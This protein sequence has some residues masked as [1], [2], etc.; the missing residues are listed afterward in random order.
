MP[1]LMYH[2]IADDGPGSLV[3]WRVPE[4]DFVRQIE[5]LAAE[6]YTSIR[7]D[8]WLTVQKRDAAALARRVVL[9][10]DDAYKDF[11][12][13]A[14]PILRRHGFGATMFVPTMNMGGVAEWDRSFGEPAP[15]MSW[16]ELDA[17]VATGLEIGAHTISHPRLT[18]LKDADEIRREVV[19]S[20]D[21]LA[22]RYKRP[23]PT[24]AYP[25]GDYNA[26]VLRVVEAAGFGVAVT[27]VP[28]SSGPLALGR[29]GIFG[30]EPFA[31]FVKKVTG[32]DET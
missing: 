13:T 5:W 28:E 1:I 29:V 10:F 32:R 31:T 22:D 20:R 23:V 7:L 16:G 25:Y 14:W 24:F 17:L 2:R 27:I 18:H 21:V 15:L 8:D 26:A 30:D 3:R 6:G 19:G 12:T 11:V 4:P 9:T